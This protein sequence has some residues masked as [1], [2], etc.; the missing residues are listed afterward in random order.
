[1]ITSIPLRAGKYTQGKCWSYRGLIDDRAPLQAMGFGLG[2]VRGEKKPRTARLA[3]QNIVIITL[4]SDLGT[5]NRLQ[6]KL[7]VTKIDGT[8]LPEA[9]YSVDVTYNGTSH[10]TT[11]DAIALQITN[12]DS[13]L[14]VTLSANKRVITITA[15]GDKKLAVHT[16]FAITGGS[17]VTVTPSYGSADEVRFRGLVEK[18]DI[19]MLLGFKGIVSAPQY[20]PNQRQMM[21]VVT[22]GDPVGPVTGSPVEGGKVYLLYKDYT[23]TNTVLNKQGTFRTNDDGGAA[24]VILLTGVEFSGEAENGLAPISL[25]KA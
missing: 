8:V 7:L 4:G 1:M 21:P 6:G 19:P 24:P 18:R 16:A 12:F 17:A 11:V 13:D 15:A 25:N 23:D 9:G 14:T 10:S 5:S 20:E 2:A 22:Q 3:H